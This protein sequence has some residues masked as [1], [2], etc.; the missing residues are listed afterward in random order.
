MRIDDPEL[1]E[2]LAQRFVVGTQRGTA[3]N[4]FAAMSAARFDIRARVDYWEARLA[5]LAWSLAPESPSQLVW[6]RICR[7]L[8]LRDSSRATPKSAAPWQALAAASAVAAIILGGGW[9]ASISRPPVT[10]TETVIERIPESVTVALVGNIEGEPI[11]LTRIRPDSGELTVR[12]LNAPEQ[13]IENDYQLWLLTSDGT[14]LSMGLM[15]QSGEQ[16]LAL[17][18]N[19]VSAIGGSTTVAVSLE[20]RG[21]SPMPV[22]TGPVLFTAALLP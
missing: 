20:P 19:V 5:P 10:V 11:W 1:V 15:P 13:T 12:V 7:N 4:R 14:P 2:L 8:G 16:T 3:R 22:P 21:G 18:D 6:P 9:W 17:N